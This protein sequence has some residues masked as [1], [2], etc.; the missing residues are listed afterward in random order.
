MSAAT[1]LLEQRGQRIEGMLRISW[2]SPQIE[3]VGVGIMITHNPLHG[4]GQAGFPAWSKNSSC[5]LAYA[6]TSLQ[7]QV[8]DKSGSLAPFLGLGCTMCEIATH[9]QLTLPLRLRRIPLVVLQQAAQ[10]LPASHGSLF[11][12]SGLCLGG[13]QDPILFPLRGCRYLLHDR[14]N[15]GAWK[16]FACQQG[17]RI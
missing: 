1:G 7:A 11:L 6:R 9:D 13:K 15:R 2:E 16:R 14:S 12:P 10:P 3:R 17:V 4:S 5:P 8:R